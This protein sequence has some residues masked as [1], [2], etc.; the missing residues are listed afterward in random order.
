MSEMRF[1]Y[2]PGCSLLS[3]SKEYDISVRAV[4]AHLGIEL[5]EIDDWNC[6]GAVHAD[7]NNANTA[8]TLPARNLAL[9]EAQE[10]DSIIAPCSGCYKNLRRASKSAAKDPKSRALINESLG[11]GLQLTSDIEVL[12]PLYVL[13]N[14]VGIERIKEYVVK[15]LTDWKI[16]SYYGCMLTR[17]KD[18]FDSTERPVGLDVLMSAL[19]ATEVNYPMKAKCC[20]GALALSHG[21]VTARLSG[22]VLLS[23]KQA[24]ADIVTL[25]CPMCHMALDVYQDKAEKQVKSSINLPVLYFTQVMGLAFGIEKSKLGF[26][27]HLVSPET[28]LVQMGF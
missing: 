5:V 16:A 17:P 22:N 6:C 18:V 28:Q 1:G 21:D 23:A 27:R 9:A 13:L 10:L 20:G 8:I 2:Y 7:V 12:H 14:T 26:E 25:A 19:S 15:P 11:D 24:G 4:F 3:S